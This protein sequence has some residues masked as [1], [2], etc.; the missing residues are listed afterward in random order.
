[1][2]EPRILDMFPTVIT[3]GE[4]YVFALIGTKSE[5]TAEG[6]KPSW[7]LWALGHRQHTQSTEWTMTWDTNLFIRFLERGK[8]DGQQEA[9]KEQTKGQG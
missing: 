4:D 3:V 7:R 9:S 8:S 1:M 6:S 5:K 2:S